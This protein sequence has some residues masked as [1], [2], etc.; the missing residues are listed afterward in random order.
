MGTIYESHRMCP[1]RSGD[2]RSKDPALGGTSGVTPTPTAHP[3][4][5]RERPVG[6]TDATRETQTG[7]QSTPRSSPVTPAAQTPHRPRP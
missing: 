5:R 7:R 1:S 4:R 2:N 6:A 3:E